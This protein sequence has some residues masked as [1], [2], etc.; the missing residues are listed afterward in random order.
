MIQAQ[1]AQATATIQAQAAQA[2]ATSQANAQMM[3][4]LLTIVAQRRAEPATSPV[5]PTTMALQLISAM[6]KLV[7]TPAV[8]PGLAEQ[9]AM[10]KA[11]RDLYQ[12]APVAPTNE[13]QP[14]MNIFGQVMAADATGTQ[15]ERAQTPTVP[16]EATNPHP[17]PRPR[18]AL[19]HVPGIGMVRVVAP[20]AS[21]L[22][23]GDMSTEDLVAAV[24]KD[25]ALLR[26]LGIGLAPEQIAPVVPMVAVAPVA[27]AQ[28]LAASPASLASRPVVD[29]VPAIPDVP[30]LEPTSILV[31]V[32]TPPAAAS[33]ASLPSVVSAAPSDATV[34]AASPEPSTSATV[35]IA[36]EERQAIALPERMPD[37]EPLH[38]AAP[39]HQRVIGGLNWL[40][41]LTQGSAGDIS[42]AA[43]VK[44][45]SRRE[46]ESKGQGRH[47]VRMAPQHR[48]ALPRSW[49]SATSPQCHRAR[50]SAGSF[51]NTALRSARGVGRGRGRQG[52]SLSPSLHASAAEQRPEASDV[53]DRDEAERYQS[54]RD[55]GARI[56]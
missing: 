17:P 56:L 23:F 44:S 52:A 54:A 20:D 28:S 35:V 34:V 9:I 38:R 24:R 2:T 40:T 30:D 1:A 25:P 11:L 18:P 42:L 55:G 8:T 12:P 26:E 46:C 29:P 13:L 31:V 41:L 37:P 15:A 7:P 49:A 43:P 3:Q 39:D 48:S 6:Q 16:Q 45:S 53:G 10:I 21:A 27:V 5:D 47:G 50:S 36:P 14:F 32:A 22:C 4:T 51:S 33:T 19:L